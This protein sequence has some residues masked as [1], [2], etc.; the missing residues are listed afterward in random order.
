[1]KKLNFSVTKLFK[2]TKWISLVAILPGLIAVIATIC[3][4]SF[5]NF[6]IDFTGGTTMQVAI[7]T[8]ASQSVCNDISDLVKDTVGVKPSMVQSTGSGTVKDE[9]IIRTSE[10]TDDQ[11]DKVFDALA[12]KYKLDQKDLLSCDNISATVG[13]DLQSVALIS[14]LVAVLLI[15]VYISIRFDL[16]SGLAAICCLAHDI[17]VIL[18]FYVIFRISMNIN[19][20]AAALTILGYSINATIVIFDR[21]REL[22]RGARKTPFEETVDKAVMQSMGR[23]INTTITT[24]VMIIMLLILGVPSI[25]NF[26]L[27]LLIGVIC[28]GYSSI[29][30]SGPLWATFRRWFPKH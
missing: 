4:A 15:L 27:P 20:I 28:G 1:M 16:R 6:D 5:F 24:L 11:A 25:R 12:A 22:A 17:L 14:S 30:V 23:S 10:L 29:C 21:V 19:F 18:S 8:E 13:K 7:H 26:M 9:V 3:G 2:V